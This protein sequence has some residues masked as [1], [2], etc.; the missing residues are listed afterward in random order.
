MLALESLIKAFFRDHWRVKLQP[1]LLVVHGKLWTSFELNEIYFALYYGEVMDGLFLS[2]QKDAEVALQL[3]REEEKRKEQAA[4]MVY[5]VNLYMYIVYRTEE[6]FLQTDYSLKHH[7]HY[8]FFV[9]C[10][11]NIF[12]YNCLMINPIRK[13][14]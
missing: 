2:T 4:N 1:D 5:V 9:S 6:Q 7:Y 8:K 14:T 12:T 3:Q 13:W 10:E 11:S